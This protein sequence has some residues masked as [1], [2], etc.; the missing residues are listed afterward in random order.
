[1]AESEQRACEVAAN[2][3]FLVA[4]RKA[5]AGVRADLLAKV[6]EEL[7]VRRTLN[8]QKWDYIL[9]RFVLPA[10]RRMHNAERSCTAQFT[11]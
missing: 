5:W 8:E 7:Q 6:D 10:R 11:A 9:E 2:E 3:A 1:M 4:Q